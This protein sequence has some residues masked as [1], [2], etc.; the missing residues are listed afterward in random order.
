M[1]CAVPVA[2]INGIR[3]MNSAGQQIMASYDA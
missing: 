1:S 3:I 2:Q